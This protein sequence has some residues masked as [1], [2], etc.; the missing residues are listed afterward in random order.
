MS[1]SS[2]DAQERVGEV[3][4][5]PQTTLL[6]SLVRRSGRWYVRLR[7]YRLEPRRRGQRS[8]PGNQGL[9]V[10]VEAVGELVA[11]LRQADTQI[12]RKPWEPP[13]SS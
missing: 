9:I 11:L 8:V 12:P 1:A 6:V 5:S 13:A 4:L 2:W 7:T 3:R 10:P